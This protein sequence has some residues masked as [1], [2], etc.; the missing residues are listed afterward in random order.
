MQKYAVCVHRRFSCDI[1][2][3]L[4]KHYGFDRIIIFKIRSKSWRNEISL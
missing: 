1:L 2:Y 3:L 4:D